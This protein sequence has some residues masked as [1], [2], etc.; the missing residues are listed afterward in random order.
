MA[1][2]RGLDNYGDWLYGHGNLDYFSKGACVGLD[3][4]TSVK[5]W[6]YNWFA[7]F[8][9]GIDWRT[10]LGSKNQKELL[11]RDV[12]EIVTSKK[13]VISVLEFTSNLDAVSRLYT[14]TIRVN[15]VYGEEAIEIKAGGA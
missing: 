6:K 12:L 10:R 4:I 13:D 7:D 5:E 15:T 3:I 8:Q 1:L 11:D 2:I 14:G 9:K